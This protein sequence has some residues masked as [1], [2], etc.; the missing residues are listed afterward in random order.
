MFELRAR[1]TLDDR[2]IV[3]EIN[4]LSYR[5]AHATLRS[6][7]ERTQVIGKRG[8]EKLDI[9]T[10]WRYIANPI[11][12]G[13]ICEKWTDNKPVKGQFPG[14]VSYELFNAA[15]KGKFVIGEKMAQYFYT[16]KGPRSAMQPQKARGT[17]NFS[18]RK[19]LSCVLV[20]KAALRTYAGKIGK[21]YP[22]LPP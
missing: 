21:R 12:A 18:Y 13:I 20:R 8:G 2:Q 6:T 14:L 5:S 11:Y 9:K 15:N 4:K 22:S 3:D 16:K 7:Q 1:G 17:P 19:K 10:F